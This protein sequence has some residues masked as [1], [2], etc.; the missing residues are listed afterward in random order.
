VLLDPQVSSPAVKYTF[1]TLL[2]E[3]LGL[4][5]SFGEEAEAGD[6]L[7][8]YYGFPE[9]CQSRVHFKINCSEFWLK[10]N[11]LT[12]GCL[13][14]V[15]LVRYRGKELPR[16]INADDLPV[17]FLAREGRRTRAEAKPPYVRAAS[18]ENCV[19]TNIDLIASSFFMLSRIEEIV[20]PMVD[21]H[22]RYPVEASLAF[23]EGFLHRPIVNEYLEFLWFWLKRVNPGLER[24]KRAFQLFL[25]HD[26][27]HI[28]VGTA[29][30]RLRASGAQLVKYR[31]PGGF[32]RSIGRNI[33]GLFTSPK[34]PF[35]FIRQTS[36]EF[37]FK[38]HFFFLSNGKS[39]QYDA[40]RYDIKSPQ[41]K[42]LIRLLEA[43]GHHIGLHCSYSSFLNEEQLN[44][45]KKALDQLVRNRHYGCRSHYLLL[46]IPESFVLLEKCRFAFD[47]SLGYA[48][49][50]GFRA[51]TCYPFKPFDVK[52]NRELDLREYPLMC[53]DGSLT[54]PIF[55]NLKSPR[56]VTRLLIEQINTVFFFNG[57]FVFLVHPDSLEEV[58][59]PWRRVFMD[60]LAHCR[61]LQEREIGSFSKQS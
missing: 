58:E 17:L 10:K 13:P 35:E 31:S 11:Y 30:S 61:Q 54:S 28:R 19:E 25:T 59:F 50:N 44:A 37:G 36:K 29:R 4:G 24:K 60:V 3:F 47:S 40:N 23:K 34:D 51:G 26:V 8:L 33:T 12:K 55:R 2:G 16:V 22:G 5:I 39:K 9:N 7:C 21:L 15:P 27:D 41:V 42:R 14:S 52:Q 48:D 53:M 46:R 57:C 43:E 6:S 32:F 45:E 18:E 1:N 49:W 20:S 38:S 56:R